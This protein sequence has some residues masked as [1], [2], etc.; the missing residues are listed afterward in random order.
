MT[1]AVSQAMLG[2]MLTFGFATLLLKGLFFL[3][4]KRT[5]KGLIYV[6]MSLIAGFLAV[7]SFHYAWGVITDPLTARH[8]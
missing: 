7:L 2:L 6:M 4:F 1:R 3:R 5:R 8:W